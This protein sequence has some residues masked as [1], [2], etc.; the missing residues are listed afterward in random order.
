MVSMIFSNSTLEGVK[1]Q[2]LK[3]SLTSFLF[4]IF[5]IWFDML[6]WVLLRYVCFC[7]SFPQI[8]VSLY[9][10]P[11]LFIVSQT[12]YSFQV[13]FSRLPVLLSLCLALARCLCTSCPIRPGF[14]FISAS[15]ILQLLCSCAQAI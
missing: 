12:N 13:S 11:C 10:N 3:L 9:N 6:N 2:D 14:S 15:F 1:T 8:Y 4:S 7:L 5:H